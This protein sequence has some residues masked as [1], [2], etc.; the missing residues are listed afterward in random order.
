LIAAVVAVVAV[1]AVIAAVVIVVRAIEQ[2]TD[3]GGRWH[4]APEAL[5]R[6][7]AG[8]E[9]QEPQCDGSRAGGREHTGPHEHNNPLAMK[10]VE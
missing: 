1:I 4:G 7:L 10:I 9:Q 2:G 6:N 8:K 3:R 5:C